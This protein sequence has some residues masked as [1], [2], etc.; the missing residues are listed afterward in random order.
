MKKNYGR[1]VGTC[2]CK[3]CGDEFE[4]PLTEINRNLKLDRPNF[5]SRSCVGKTNIKNFGEKRFH[6]DDCNKIKR[7]GDQ[8]TMF[9]Y[10]YRTI[11]SRCRSKG[12][13]LDITIDDLKRQW[14]LQNGICQF[15]GINLVLSSYSKINKD[16]IYNASLDRIDSSK[17]Y[18]K[19]NIRWV[20]RAINWMKNSMNDDQVW[21]LC[22]LISENILKLELPNSRRVEAFNM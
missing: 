5:C 16:P 8:Y 6:L 1:K 12:I 2:V 14:E 4:K 3:N 13:E 18:I 9:K 11:V 7:Y 15:T 20:S 10:H 19:G 21:V 22:H 17:G